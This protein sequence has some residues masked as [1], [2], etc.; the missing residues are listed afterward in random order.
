M[1]MNDGDTQGLPTCQL[2]TSSVLLSP[3]PLGQSKPHS[4]LQYLCRSQTVFSNLG[5]VSD[6]ALHF[7]GS[8]WS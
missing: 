8:S 6:T 5:D 3:H 7:L 4:Q 1:T 2:Q